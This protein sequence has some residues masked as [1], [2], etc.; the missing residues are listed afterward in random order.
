MSSPEIIA[1]ID[2]GS[3]GNPGPAAYGVSIET[4]QGEPVTAF[5]RFLG[6]TT[7]NFAEYQ[8]LLAALD[9]ALTQGYPRLRV[10]TDSEL[11]AR[12]ISGQYKVRSP[13]LKPLYDKAREMIARL[14]SFSIRHVYREQNREADRLANQAMDEA[15]RGAG[16]KPLSPG[17]A[18]PSSNGER[19]PEARPLPSPPSPR[20]ST[21]ASHKPKPVTATFQDG[22]L[23]PHTQLPSFDGE[24]VELE[25]HRKK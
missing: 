25:I 16:S 19:S 10:L 1:H 17:T 12:Q 23:H 24:E 7:N 6:R 14:E 5:A 4:K 2:G 3:R 22:A 8:G 15:E 18:T 11:M 20:P 9:F 21:P 13:D